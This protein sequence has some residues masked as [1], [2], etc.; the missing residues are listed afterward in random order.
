MKGAAFLLNTSEGNNPESKPH[1][2]IM[3]TKAIT[4][5]ESGEDECLLVNISSVR[6]TVAFYD[7]TCVLLPGDHEFIK[8]ESYVVY[9]EA[10]I[11][12]LTELQKD[13]LKSMG[14]VKDSVFEL[15]CKGLEKIGIYNQKSSGILPKI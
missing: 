9:S 2:F 10:R 4:N 6:K 13:S 5:K 14:M 7:T 12:S 1:L 11:E 15:I 8:H 3:L